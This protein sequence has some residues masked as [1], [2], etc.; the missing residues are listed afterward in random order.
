MLNDYELDLV[1][2]SAK[3]LHIPMGDKFIWRTVADRL[4]GLATTLDHYSHLPATEELTELTMHYI[5]V[6]QI[7]AINRDIRQT[8]DQK[9]LVINDGRPRGSKGKERGK[10]NARTDETDCASRPQ[11][12]ELGAL[13]R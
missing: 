8:A 9:G 6:N 2:R 5:V 11:L 12:V 13:K 3:R 1:G 7:N 4:R 10:D